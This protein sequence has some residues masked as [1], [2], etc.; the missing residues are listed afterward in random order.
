MPHIAEQLEQDTEVRD[1][2]AVMTSVWRA[3]FAAL[4]E[5]R[6]AAYVRATAPLD[7]E[8]AQLRQEH[9]C[10][11]EAA[12]ELELLLPAKARM[13]QHEADQLLLAGKH[14]EARAKVQEA[15]EAKAAP[16]RMER[17]QAGISARIADLEAQKK[18]ALK[19]AAEDFR[20]ACIGLIRDCEIAL[21]SILDKTRDSLNNLEV[22][23]NQTLYQPAQLTCDERSGTWTTLHRMYA[24]RVR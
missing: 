14:E 18:M 12:Q 15:E 22:E 6:N 9:A 8:Q 17:R 10:I 20:D 13:A 11:A 7:R 5:R 23:L 3:A 21:A 16:I 2:A 24:G 1:M 4:V 19:A